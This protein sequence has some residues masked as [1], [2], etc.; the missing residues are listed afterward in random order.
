MKEFKFRYKDTHGITC[1][2]TLTLP[3][4]AVQFCDVDIDGNEVYENDILVG[5]D[6]SE[7]AAEFVPCVI[8]DD[9]FSH[10]LPFEYFHLAEA[11]R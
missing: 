4:D 8:S 9:G 11:E 2:K 3:D 5:S 7:W 1:Y 6:G 10:D